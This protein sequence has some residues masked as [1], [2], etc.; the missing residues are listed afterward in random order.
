MQ[1]YISPLSFE[2]TLSVRNQ[3]RTRGIL[4]TSINN[5]YYQ[6]IYLFSSHIYLCLYKV[7][8]YAEM[9]ASISYL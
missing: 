5:Q 4:E 8:L 9:Q 7:Y 3:D 2:R 6:V 1:I